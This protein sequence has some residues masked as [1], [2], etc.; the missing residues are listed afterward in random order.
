MGCST[1]NFSAEPDDPPATEQ[2]DPQAEVIE[3]D[4]ETDEAVAIADPVSVQP[5]TVM[6]NLEHPWG[7]AWLPDG[8]LLVTERPGRLRIVRDGDLD[9]NP[10]PGLPDLLS[11]GQGG[12]LDIA[13]HPQ[14]DENRWV[15]FT[16]SDGTRDANQTLVGRAEF[17]GTTLQ[18]WTVVFEVGR[19]KPDTQ[20]FGA[21]MAWLPDTTL[22]VS[23]G[24]GGNPPVRLDGELIRDQA[25]D[26]SSRLGKIVRIRDDGSIPADN[27]FVGDSNADDAVWSYG[28]RNIQ[29]L[30]VDPVTEQVW[31]TEHGARGGDELNWVRA[32]ENYGWP[33]VTHSMEYAGG[34]IS[35]ERSRPGMVDPSLV[36]TP[37]KAPSGLLIYRGDRIPQW[38]GHL[39]AGGLQSQ[40][41]LRIQVDS[42][43][44]VVDQEAIAIGQRVR[45]VRQGPDGLIYV[46]TDE[47]NGRLLR[48]EPDA[49]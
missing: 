21:R 9:P 16:Y 24:D 14:F 3:T 37:A 33:V 12:L 10:V 15:Y 36:W 38:Q 31:A 28:H 25:Q 26:L 8:T 11:V 27:P 48:L 19:T 49:G 47:S 39:F 43:G 17:D 32:G 6:E 23:I 42:A 22:L 4:E 44:N 7:M 2:G 45:D 34:E 18:N 13:V 40:E 41:V 1:P 46:L 35:T 29:G 20:H 30:D 5:V